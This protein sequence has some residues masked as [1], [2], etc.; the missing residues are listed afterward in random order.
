MTRRRR[1][2][3]GVALLALACLPVFNAPADLMLHGD[4]LDAA[5]QWPAEIVPGTGWWKPGRDGEFGTNDDE[6]PNLFGDV[7]LVARTGT[8]EITQFIPAQHTL[9]SAP[10]ITVAPFGAGQPISFAVTSTTI[11]FPPQLGSPTNAPSLENSPVLVF[12]F[13]DL[14][15][16]GAIGITLRDGNAADSEIEEAELLPVG[17]TLAIA[18][19]GRAS[20]KLR[21][22]AG[23]PSGAP[24]TLMIGAAAWAGSFDPNYENG[25]VPRGPLV[26]TQLPF[27]PLTRPIDV[28]DAGP[29]GPGPANP[30]EF[31]GI[32]NDAH[33]EPDPADPR[34][35][36]SY[37]LFLDGSRTTTDLALARSGAFARV[38][39]VQRPV[40]L[41]YVTLASRPLRP[42]FDDAGARVLYEVL[43]MLRLA[44]DGTATRDSLRL[45]PLDALGN[46]AD[47][48]AAETVVL[49]ASG[50][51]RIVS[52][53]LDGDLLRETLTLSDSRGVGVEIDDAG[54][55]W[56]GA[57]AGALWV[58]GATGLFRATATLP[59]PDVND[60][61]AVTAADVSA[62]RAL[63]GVSDG[64]PGFD[65]ALDLTGDGRIERD[66]ARI[67]TVALGQTIAVP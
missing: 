6:F 45:V 4:W 26:M 49:H 55:A 14:D 25:V 51:V 30:D 64:E 34:I 67:A 46:V 7:D 5:A 11:A 42:G 48:P 65:A 28:L 43:G 56:D 27:R 22:S 19:A 33:A 53:N 13:A 60:S 15:G 29:F 57:N 50:P 17:R 10:V 20:G 16:D 39:L 21:V 62:I 44:D 3:V 63:R 32:R 41:E 40:P 47:L 31:I 59:D 36:E 58:D 35:G 18:H 54:G 9:A 52:P 24:L 38:G 1:L 66:D 12:A 37:T 23:G 2:S 8:R 61:G